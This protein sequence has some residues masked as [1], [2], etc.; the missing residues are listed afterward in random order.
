[1]IPLKLLAAAP[2]IAKMSM[3]NPE[4]PRTLAMVFQLQE[5]AVPRLEAVIRLL[6]AAGFSG[7]FDALSNHDVQSLIQPLL[8]SREH[9]P[10]PPSPR[11][12]VCKHCGEMNLIKE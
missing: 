1:M 5:D 9:S 3:D 2:T 12:V 4:L 6:S 7:V 10:S 11:V 8:E